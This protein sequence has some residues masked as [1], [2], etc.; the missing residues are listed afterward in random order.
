MPGKEPLPPVIDRRLPLAQT[1]EA[2]RYVELGHK[3]RSVV[4]NIVESA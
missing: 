3:K 1:A 4:L 2:H